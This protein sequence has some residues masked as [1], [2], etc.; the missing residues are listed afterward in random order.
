MKAGRFYGIDVH[1]HWTFWLLIAIY[2]LAVAQSSG[3]AQGL[4]AVALILAVFFCV[5]LH[6]YG[7]AL[8]ARRFGIR[9]LDITLMP[10]GGLAR[11]E[12][13]PDRPWQEFVIA[14]AGPLVNVAI[15]VLLLPL[16]LLDLITTPAAPAIQLGGSLLSQL[17]YVNIVLVVFNM[18]PAFPMDGGRVLR[19]LLAMKLGQ[20]RATS[21]AARVGR[22]MALLF[23]IWA[24]FI[25]WNPMLLLLA[26]FI[27]V[28]GTMEL[29]QVKMQSMQQQMQHDQE[30]F[31][32]SYSWGNSGADDSAPPNSQEM[33][34]DAI[35][36]RRI[37]RNAG[38]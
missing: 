7:H 27:F 28:T 2:L 19:S 15:A 16:V 5:L 1:I 34:I 21:I 37:D 18:L 24:V 38:P 26:G 33:I 31:R 30:I 10:I 29:L 20:L 17:M 13:L 11:L 36:V 25:Q 35:E 9:T 22:W 6:E 4:L 8:A 14:V 3:L 32:R 12:R 23:A